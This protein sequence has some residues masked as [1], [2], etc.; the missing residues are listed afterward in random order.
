[1]S[2]KLMITRGLPGSGK[3]TWA[4][5]Q[6]Q[7]GEFVFNIER[8]MLRKEFLGDFATNGYDFM[9]TKFESFIT[10]E[11]RRRIVEAFNV[12]D[13]VIASDTN[14][15][16]KSVR[17]WSKFAESLGVEFHVQDFRS[18]PLDT[19]LEQNLLRDDAVPEYVIM[20]KY[21][22]FIKGK[23]LSIQFVPTTPTVPA[24][25][26]RV[27]AEY[28][29]GLE[30]IYLVDIDGT[31]A[32][33]VGK[34]DPY[35][36]LLAHMDELKSDVARVVKHLPYKVI[37]FTG[38]E[39]RFRKITEDWLIDNG[40]FTVGESLLFMRE[41]GDG[42]SDDAVKYEMFDTYIRGQYNV[43]GVFDDRDRVVRMWREW[44]GLTCFQVD[45]GDF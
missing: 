29:E 7:H 25:P 13:T 4:K 16:D 33:N 40:L 9:D 12:V 6:R 23:D 37:F 2:K 26:T 10:A 14:L 18:V 34:R 42:R 11:I 19:V 20:A 31:L 41:T 27:M 44:L 1:M 30:D 5:A 28:T 8:D 32:N 15:P 22:R 38:R 24:V 21:V 35:D 43:L 17:E 45:Y 3:S 39:D 36:F